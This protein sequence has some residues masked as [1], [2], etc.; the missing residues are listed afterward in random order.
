MSYCVDYESYH[1]IPQE[2][3]V[4]SREHCD[5]SISWGDMVFSFPIC[6]ANMTSVVDEKTCMFLSEN[7]MF[8]VMHRFGISLK[9]FCT[10]MIDNGHYAS[11]SVG[12]KDKSYD[13]LTEIKEYGICPEY[14]T[15]DVANAWSK[16]TRNML[17]YLNENFKKSF[18]ILGNVATPSACE[19][20][21][22]WG[23]VDAIKAG[24]AGG[25]VCITKNKTG[26]HVPMV[27]CVRDCFS[28]C[29][30]NNVFLIADGGIKEHGDVAKAISL[31]AD[32]VMAGS[33]FAGYDQSAGNIIEIEKYVYKEYYGNASKDN[34][35]ERKN[36]EGKKILIDYKGDMGKLLI[37]LK[38]DLQ[39]SISYAGGESLK[40]LKHTPHL[41]KGW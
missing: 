10:L 14:I 4:P 5:T 24:I 30:K 8:Y 3:I 16:D 29:S 39:S 18:I 35:K 17:K 37:E 26:F 20:V 15:I 41:V 32:M 25:S 12:V 21:L 28:V 36:V 34:K 31:G 22:S 7:N 19:D 6:P 38:E 11:V 1:L 23:R 27:Q 40:D 13:Q 2:C 9:E 33:L